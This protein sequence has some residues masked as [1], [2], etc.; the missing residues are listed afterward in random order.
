[1]QAHRNIL[2]FPVLMWTAS[3]EF[4]AFAGPEVCFLHW[5]PL[6]YIQYSVPLLS[7]ENLHFIKHLV[8]ICII[9]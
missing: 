2:Y 6:L 1:M 8:Q 3:V 4:Y 9:S 5:K 7:D